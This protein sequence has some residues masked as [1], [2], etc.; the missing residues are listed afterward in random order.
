MNL[1]VQDFWEIDVK[2]IIAAEVTQDIALVENTSKSTQRVYNTFEKRLTPPVC[3]AGRVV[4]LLDCHAV[5]PGLIPGL[6]T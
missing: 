5:D 4:S 1:R 6:N 2:A 3:V